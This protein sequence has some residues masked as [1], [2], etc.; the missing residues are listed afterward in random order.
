MDPGT[1]GRTGQQAMSSLY[2]NAGVLTKRG[3]V[4]MAS[5]C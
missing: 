3:A 4:G 5:H 2:S 1:G